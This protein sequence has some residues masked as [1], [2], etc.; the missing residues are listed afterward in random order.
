MARDDT[1]GG[2]VIYPEAFATGE[3]AKTATGR[4]LPASTFE[5][6]L[7]AE[8]SMLGR[9]CDLESLLDRINRALAD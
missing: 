3:T 6:L 7:Q 5:R 1:E 9:L 2:R 4:R 8:W